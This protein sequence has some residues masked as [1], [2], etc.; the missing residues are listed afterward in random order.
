MSPE[1]ARCLI[2]NKGG[3]EEFQVLGPPAGG[4][5]LVEVF[6]LPSSGS[7]VAKIMSSRASL[8]GFKSA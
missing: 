4:W 5:M 3:G 6:V 7:T 8:P 2:W 1:E